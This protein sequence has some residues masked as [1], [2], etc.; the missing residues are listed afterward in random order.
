MGIGKSESEMSKK[1]EV[2]NWIGTD[3]FKRKNRMTVSLWIGV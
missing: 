2:R 3:G 1:E